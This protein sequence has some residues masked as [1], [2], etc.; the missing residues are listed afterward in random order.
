MRVLER[1][2]I[3]PADAALALV[4]SALGCLM[5]SDPDGGAGN[6]WLAGALILLATVPVAWRRRTPL[7][8]AVTLAVGT[9]A[10][11][12][13]GL[14]QTR[15]GVVIPSALLILYALATRR[16]RSPALLGLALVLAAMV[17][18]AFTDQTIEP[19][20]LSFVLPL[21]AGVW[22]TGRLVR[23]RSRLAS[24]LAERSRQ[25]EAQR[26]RTAELAVEVER[27]RLSAALDAAARGRVLEIVAL[28]ESGR[29]V[30]ATFARIETAGRASLND[31]RGLL[32][33]LRA[34]A[35][36]DR[37]PQPT[38]AQLDGLLAG[39]AL[40][41]RGERRPLPDGVEL[42]A[43]RTVEHA[44]AALDGTARTV[45]LSYGADA[46]ELEVAGEP[47]SDAREVVAA[48]R[49]RVAAHGGRLELEGASAGRT[50]VHAWLPVADG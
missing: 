15:C 36:P 49:E 1:H 44:L 35:A 20:A 11:A 7:A 46:L 31:M 8:A 47:A 41:V 24:E 39:A 43:Y 22:A 30:P 28:T 14:D 32:G 29:P 42:A 45:R 5:A 34:D 27:E 23:S 50:V 3:S 13:P 21:C 19:A 25:L 37:A 26:R 9:V 2:R 17:V 6:A 10:S 48:A 40:D 33:V 38:L 4:L 18:L 16:E 12:G